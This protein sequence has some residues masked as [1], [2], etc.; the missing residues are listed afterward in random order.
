MW[1]YK[2]VFYLTS[3]HWYPWERFITAQSSPASSLLG[4]PGAQLVKS[5]SWTEWCHVHL[6][7]DRESPFFHDIY[8]PI[9]LPSCPK[10]VSPMNHGL[11]PTNSSSSMAR[12][13]W[14]VTSITLIVIPSLPWRSV[15]P[16]FW[17]QP[18]NLPGIHRAPGPLSRRSFLQWRSG[19]LLNRTRIPVCINR[20]QPST[21]SIQPSGQTPSG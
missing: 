20:K 4:Y 6:H 14:T 8:T 7:T 5:A 9:Y 13:S 18:G 10:S 15:G 21:D 1:S 11:A 3:V 2:V 19:A 12:L 17:S 16:L